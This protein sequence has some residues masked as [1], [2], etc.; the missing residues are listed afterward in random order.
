LANINGF[1]EQS[2]SSFSQS[3]PANENSHPSSQ[4][5]EEEGNRSPRRPY[6]NLFDMPKQAPLIK[7][8]FFE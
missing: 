5:P 6:Q 4:I 2:S 1:F 8:S 7:Q 3:N